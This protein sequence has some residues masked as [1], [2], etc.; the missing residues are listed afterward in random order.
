MPAEITMVVSATEFPQFR[1]LVEFAQAVARH[2]DEECDVALQAL[3]H[4][5]HDDLLRLR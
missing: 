3:V 2:A 4:E 5:L 1:R